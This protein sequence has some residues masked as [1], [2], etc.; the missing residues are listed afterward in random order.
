MWNGL[1]LAASDHRYIIQEGVVCNHIGKGCE[2][3]SLVGRACRCNGVGLGSQVT[4]GKGTKHVDNPNFDFLPD[5]TLVS[6]YLNS[7]ND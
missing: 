5:A 7:E 3:L 4:Q 6:V 1:G 2:P